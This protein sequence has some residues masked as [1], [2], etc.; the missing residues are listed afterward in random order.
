MIATMGIHIATAG[1]ADFHQAL[2]D[3]PRFWGERDLRSPHLLALVQEF[4]ST[5]LAARTEDR[6]REYIYGFVT[7]DSTGCLHPTATQDD[8][9]GTPLARTRQP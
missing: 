5:C 2:T 9:P 4:G 6:I 7:P 3:H 1:V 8:A